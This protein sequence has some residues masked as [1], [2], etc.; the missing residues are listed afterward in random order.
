M[1]DEDDDIEDDLEPVFKCSVGASLDRDC[2]SMPPSF[3]QISIVKEGP[4]NCL[5]FSL[6][7]EGDMFPKP[8]FIEI[9]N[10]TVNLNKNRKEL[11]ILSLA[12]RPTF[13][14]YFRSLS[15]EF[16]RFFNT[17]ESLTASSP[18]ESW[19]HD[20]PVKASKT[21]HKTGTGRLQQLL[22]TP[23][24]YTPTNTMKP[25]P[26]AGSNRAHRMLAAAQTNQIMTSANSPQLR[27]SASPSCSSS[28][29]LLKRKAHESSSFVTSSCP[30]PSSLV[31]E[32]YKAVSS[33]SSSPSFLSSSS[34]ERFSYDSDEDRFSTPTRLSSSSS[35]SSS[36][37]TSSKS[38][39]S[40][41]SSV[42][43][44]S[45]ILRHVT[46]V[47]ERKGF[48]NV[49]NSCYLNA[50]LQGLLGLP[51][52]VKDLIEIGK[53]LNAQ[54]GS[55]YECLMRIAHAKMEAKSVVNVKQ[56]KDVMG[57]KYPR[58]AGNAQQ[59]AQEFL[60]A[61]L[62]YLHEDVQD[63]AKE[64]LQSTNVNT[65]T[66][67]ATASEKEPMTEEERRKKSLICFTNATSAVFQNFYC[68]LEFDM[69]CTNEKCGFTRKIY[70][71]FFDFSLD[72]E[73][74]GSSSES[75][76]EENSD[77]NNGDNA[78][79]TS[80]SSTS[81]KPAKKSLR[82]L[83][84]AYFTPRTMEYKCSECKQN[85][86]VLQTPRISRLPRVLVLHL[87]RFIPSPSTQTYQKTTEP[88]YVP[89]DL[90]LGDFVAENTLE[91]P[92]LSSS[93]SSSSS[94][95]FSSS[96]SSLASPPLLSVSLNGLPLTNTASRF[97]LRSSSSS[98]SS[99]SS[100]SSGS[101]RTSSAPC[102]I[103]PSHLSS[104]SPK[105]PFRTTID[106]FD[107]NIAEQKDN[108]LSFSK[109]SNN[110]KKVLEFEDAKDKREL[111]EWFEEKSK[112]KMTSEE[113]LETV[114]EFTRKLEEFKSST[115]LA[116]IPGLVSENEEVTPPTWICSA[117]TLEN[118]SSVKE[119]AVCG[120][121]AKLEA[122]I[123]TSVMPGNFPLVPYSL[124]EIAVLC[125]EPQNQ[126]PVS[127]PA[128]HIRYSL[129]CVISHKGLTWS[130]GHYITDVLGDNKQW[131]RFDDQF[132][133]RIAPENAL[134]HTAETQGYVFFFINDHFK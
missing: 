69:K 50:V 56:L 21:V 129:R 59:D 124:Q 114:M 88:V 4:K 93:S 118:Q 22:K 41:P 3:T 77:K 102:S 45:S 99:T 47:S 105:I 132:V 71:H 98:S 133:Q 30:S 53:K 72:I 80:N 37:S 33:S 106:P 79:Y 27:F 60:S 73:P 34:R 64:L 92:P 78:R 83:L 125:Q 108:T 10:S 7:L 20:I 15:H 52:F 16:L 115:E 81:K 35:F 66:Y 25:P 42:D 18:P 46:S 11:Q 111:T 24:G 87:K 62:N 43:K 57:G 5:K 121:P 44:Q 112:R 58:F 36:Y 19:L 122:E 75:K 110:A 86:E 13:I 65:C 54:K 119:C 29:L 95:S 113:E 100:S 51:T 28:S 26:G 61:C 126:I 90:D 109:A 96:S 103:S 128:G 104:P 97:S 1:N 14:I 55:V 31:A 85:N 91:P 101:S 76:K 116:S 117:C 9:S 89:D 40:F 48:V 49:G 123:V 12:E 134:R 82:D 74:T 8:Y 67:T 84:Q 94:L 63:F 17:L 130:S 6:C 39:S 32:K 68:E 120:H 107:F 23:K 38:T 2:E 70:E 127:Q 131:T